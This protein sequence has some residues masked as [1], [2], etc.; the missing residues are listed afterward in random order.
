MGPRC[1]LGN[2]VGSYEVQWGWDAKHWPATELQVKTRKVKA[3]NSLE[4][5]LG[6]LTPIF[7]KLPPEGHLMKLS[8]ILKKLPLASCSKPHLWNCD[9]LFYSASL[10]QEF[11]SY[12]LN[13]SLAALKVPATARQPLR[14]TRNCPSMKSW[15]CLHLLQKHDFNGQ[16]ASLAYRLQTHRSSKH[17]I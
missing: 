14:A 12:L 9:L 11:S 3:V 10:P 13:R 17:H 1:F 5:L 4:N 2:H 15:P 16:M 8:N 6:T 7:Q